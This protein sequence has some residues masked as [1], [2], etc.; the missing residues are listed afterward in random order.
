MAAV[1]T[2]Y[3]LSP[4][5]VERC[6]V[7]E[8][9]CAAGGNMLP[10]AEALPEA[11]FVGID[12]SARQIEDGLSAV[13]RLGLSNVTLRR[14]DIL[15]VTDADGRFDYVIAHGIYSWVPPHVREKVL[16]VC[17]GNL[18]PDGVAYVSYKCYPGAYQPQAIRELVLYHLRRFAGAGPQ[19]RVRQARAVLDLI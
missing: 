12:L 15:D 6:R 18:S 5:G 17:A 16:E 19:E 1:A 7:L 11:T 10:M 9:G 3:G 2:L 14:Q 8:L 4:P 13:R